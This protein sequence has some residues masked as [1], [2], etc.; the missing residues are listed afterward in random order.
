MTLLYLGADH[1]GFALKERL[2]QYLESK[3]FLIRDFGAWEY[4]K[5]DDY[6][7]YAIPVAEMTVRTK[8]KG[9]LVCG[10]A[11][12]IAIAANKVRGAR[13]VP[14]WDVASAKLSRSHNDANI[15]CLA[16]GKTVTRAKGIGLSLPKAKKIVDAWLATPFSSEQRHLRRLKKIEH[17]ENR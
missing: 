1:A 7:D 10:S 9:I 11:E 12:G 2:K 16:G 4:D 14:V 8:G 15:L 6:P 5:N 13:A 3:G 17:Y